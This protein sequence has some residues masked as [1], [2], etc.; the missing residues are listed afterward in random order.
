M[1]D[2]GAPL[3]VIVR[4]HRNARGI[5]DIFMTKSLSSI[6]LACSLVITHAAN[7]PLE[8]LDLKLMTTGY[9]KVLSGLSVKEKP[10]TI[11]GRVFQTGVGTHAPSEALIDL[12]G[13]ATHFSAEVGIDSLDNTQGSVEFIVYGDDK[14]LWNSGLCRGGEPPKACEVDLTGIRKLHLEVTDGDDGKSYDHADWAEAA[15]SFDGALP[16]MTAVLPL[17]EE[18]FILTPAA[19]D[20]PHLNGPKVRGVRPGSPLAFRIPATGERPMQFAAMGLPEGLVVDH[21][22]GIVTGTIAKGGSYEIVLEARNAEGAD[23]RRLKIVVGETLALTPT[24]GWNSWYIHYHRVTDKVMREAADQMIASGMADYGYEY[25]NIDDCWA[26]KPDSKDPQLSGSPRDAEGRITGNRNFP[27]MPG[28][29][30]YIHSKGL[31]AGLYT[32]PGKVTCAGYEGSFM[33]E[34]QDAATF[35]S[36]GFDFLKYDWCSFGREP[37]GAI[38]GDRLEGPYLLMASELRKQKRDIV[39]NLCQYGMGDVWKWGGD[40]GQSWRT[41]GDL[42]LQAGSSLPGFYQIGMTNAKCHVYARPG[43]WND[44]DYLL[45]GWVGD[46]SS[47]G[48]GKKTTL[49]PNEQYSYMS[50]WS[51]MA[52]PLVFSGDMAKL[53]PFTLNIL[54]NREVIDVDQDELGKQASILRQ[55]P[56]EFVLVKELSDGSKA[57]GLFNLG[58]KPATLRVDWTDLGISGKQTIHDVWRQKDL[59]VS[60]S[61]FGTEIPRHGVAFVRITPAR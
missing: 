10:L 50:M 48:K 29:A 57:V 20:A 47:S 3:V 53:D 13:K 1:E 5:S 55:S 37:A 32:S 35:A 51:L 21:A 36:W 56:K 61:G 31:K 40:C 16:R 59:P 24:M 2:S 4:L 7:V 19:P 58:R 54:C 14:E 39:F 25:V 33:H 15:I 17:R 44:P 46:A 45:V 22:T 34:A 60:D 42:G 52:S 43:G 26:M 41:T 30:S 6:F 49:T 28:L 8:D 9:G 27:D 12:D 23:Q 18:E 11:G 38:P